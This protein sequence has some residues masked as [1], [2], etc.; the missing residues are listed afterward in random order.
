MPQFAFIAYDGPGG[1]EKRKELR[2]PHLEHLRALDA[3]G[4]IVFASPL[5]SDD[6]QTMIGSLLIF[7]GADRAEVEAIIRADPYTAGGLF[8]STRLHP[9]NQVLPKPKED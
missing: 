1:P 2:P 5:Y 8:E 3:Q 4:K 6:R 7:E 9:V